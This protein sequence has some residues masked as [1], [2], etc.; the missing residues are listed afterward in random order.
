MLPKSI[1]KGCCFAVA[2]GGSSQRQID[3]GKLEKALKWKSD[4]FSR[5]L[6]HLPS[7]GR[8]RTWRYDAGSQALKRLRQT[9]AAVVDRSRNT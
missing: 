3:Q 5:V 7:V 4:H 2:F 8:N 1:P 6:Q 9:I